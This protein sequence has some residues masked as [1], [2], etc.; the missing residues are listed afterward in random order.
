MGFDT[1]FGLP[2]AWGNESVGMYS[3]QGAMPADMPENVHMHKGLFRD[4]L[5]RFLD[6]HP[7]PVRFMNVDCDLYSSTKDIFDHLFT[8]IAPGTIIR[9]DEYV[10][11]PRWQLDE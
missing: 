9:F 10:M 3:T 7:G 5:P 1:F 2:E 8:R 4:T 6:A 11:H